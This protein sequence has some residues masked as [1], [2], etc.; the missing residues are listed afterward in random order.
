VAQVVFQVDA[1]TAAEIFVLDFDVYVWDNVRS[2]IK[3]DA[4]LYPSR[5]SLRNSLPG[6]EPV[7][8]TEGWTD[9]EWE[10]W[11]TWSETIVGHVRSQSGNSESDPGQLCSVLNDSRNAY[12]TD[13]VDAVVASHVCPVRVLPPS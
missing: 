2:I 5:F 12:S 4:V 13:F 9:A 3:P 8:K 7:K 6:S 10:A 1:H 11:Q